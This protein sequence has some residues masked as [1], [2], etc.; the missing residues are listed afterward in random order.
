[1]N[2]Y[3][4]NRQAWVKECREEKIA[5]SAKYVQVHS[6]TGIKE[7][8]FYTVRD[9]REFFVN[10]CRLFSDSGRITVKLVS[11]QKTGESGV[12]IGQGHVFASM[13]IGT[14]FDRVKALKG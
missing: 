8:R 5:I 11:Y 9:A 12:G 7:Q 10:S 4:E 2:K 14:G 3:Q 6:E 13:Y 1:M